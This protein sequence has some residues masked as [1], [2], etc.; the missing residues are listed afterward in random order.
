M[1]LRWTAAGLL[2][3]Q[4]TFRRLKAYRQLPVLDAA[5]R[6]AVRSKVRHSSR[7]PR[8]RRCLSRTFQHWAGHRQDDLLQG[9]TAIW[10][11]A[12]LA[13]VPAGLASRTMSPWKNRSSA[14]GNWP[15]GSRTPRAILSRKPR[16]SDSQ[17]ARPDHQPGLC[18]HQAADEFRLINQTDFALKVIAAAGSICRPFSTII[19]L[20]YRWRHH[21]E[22]R[23]DENP[24]VGV[25]SIR[26]RPPMSSTNRG[27][28]ATMSSYIGDLA[29]WLENQGMDHVRG[30]V[31]HQHWDVERVSGGSGSSLFDVKPR[32]WFKRRFCSFLIFFLLM[33]AC[34]CPAGAV[35]DALVVALVVVVITKA[36]IWFSRSPGR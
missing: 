11:S 17:G 12:K 20:H 29:E 22:G 27:C 18:R 28:S 21:H 1:A 26:M 13:T 6:E 24:Q 19:P 31:R 15:S 33:M 16:L 30:A 9:M 23:C 34:R 3:A 4:K 8:I 32:R 2:E 25:G 7:W 14:H 35:A 10:P 36:L 5:L